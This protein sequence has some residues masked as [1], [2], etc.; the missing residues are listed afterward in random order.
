VREREPQ[1][2]IAV[3]LGA[4]HMM[5][6]ALAA[7]VFLISGSAFAAEKASYI[8]YIPCSLPAQREFPI[9]ESQ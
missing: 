8:G 9:K 5:D 6:R 7:I 1:A 4:I 3:Q 2:G